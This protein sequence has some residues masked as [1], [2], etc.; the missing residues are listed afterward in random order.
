MRISLLRYENKLTLNIS[1]LED[2]QSCAILKIMLQPIVEN[3]I[4]HGILQKSE[5]SGTVWIDGRTEENTIVLT[6]HD[7]GVGISDEN[8][9]TIMD[10]QTESYRGSG[11]GIK[12]I[13]ERIKLNY[14]PQ[15]GLSFSSKPGEGTTVSI[16][17]PKTRYKPHME[18]PK[19][20]MVNPTADES[21]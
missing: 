5:K 6:I 11:Y 14:G 9:R 8:L 20:A 2:I 17:V 18:P 4:L 16:R 21:M 15:F 13:N 19:I 12:N 1:V 10:H 3:A 7:N